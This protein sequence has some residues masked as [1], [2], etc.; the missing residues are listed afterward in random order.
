MLKLLCIIGHIKLWICINTHAR[1]HTHTH[2]RARSHK[3]CQLLGSILIALDQQRSYSHIRDI[4]S[5][6]NLLSLS[7]LDRF[8]WLW[9]DGFGRRKEGNSK[10]WVVFKPLKFFLQRKRKR[11]KLC[12]PYSTRWRTGGL[13]GSKVTKKNIKIQWLESLSWNMRV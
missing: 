3:L 6:E 10:M 7:T 13:L 1:E 2:M 4:Y 12:F 11:I 9:D 8:T 5:C